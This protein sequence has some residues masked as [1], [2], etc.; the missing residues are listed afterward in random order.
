MTA[1]ATSGPALGGV[2]RALVVGLGVSGAAAVRALRRA[3]ITVRVVEHDPRAAQA[4]GLP[5]DVELAA[6]SVTPGDVVEGCDLVVVSPGVRPDA[7]VRVAATRA[8]LE[9]V[10]EPELAWRLSVSPVRLVAVTGTNGKTTV[11]ELLAACLDAPAAGN[12][13]TA[14]CDL[15]TDPDRRPPPVVVAELSSFQ[16]VGADRL[17]PEVAVVTNLA[18]DH[19]D[20]HGSFVAY[21]AAKARIWARQGATDVALVGADAE[22]SGLLEAH[23]PPGRAGVL[24]GPD[25]AAAP[26][27]L[28]RAEVQGRR[29]VLRRRRG[30]AVP[31]VDVATLHRAAPHDLVNVCTAVTAAVAAGADPSHL[32]PVLRAHRPGAHRL[33]P[34]GEVDGV[35]Y[36]DDS[37]ATNPAAAAASLRTHPGS[38]GAGDPQLVWIAGGLAKGLAFDP[39][40]ALLPGRV[41]T[42]VTIGTS[43]PVLAALARGVGVPTVEAGTLDAAVRAAGEAARPGDT[44]LLAPACASM[45]Q[46]RDYAERGDRFAAAVTQLHERD[47]VEVGR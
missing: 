19:L 8:G 7:P 47:P 39:L 4:A 29:V 6:P 27:D 33:Q 11:T 38:A 45:D 36:L 24:W 20:W 3:G 14:L 41:R 10:G 15:L 2:A 18:P 34:V 26:C 42:V 23:P 9:V 31:V 44:V 35:R 13:G 32:G 25:A 12:I 21:A 5:T 46:F 22:A 1:A 28:P 40:A 30:A 43:G 17:A 37:K 16:L